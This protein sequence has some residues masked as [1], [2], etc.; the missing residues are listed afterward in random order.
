MVGAV[1][2]LLQTK[3]G[4]V[5]ARPQNDVMDAVFTAVSQAIDVAP[6]ELQ[7]EIAEAGS[8]VAVIEAHGGDVTAVR[9]AIIAGLNELPNAADLDVEQIADS[10][11]AE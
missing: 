1:I 3:T 7:A 4:E 8:L 5:Q 6:E 2:R 11:L 10:W 9:D